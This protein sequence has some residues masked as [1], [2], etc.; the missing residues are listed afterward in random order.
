MS[1]YLLDTNVISELT[2]TPPNSDVIA[3]LLRE[4][5][6]WVPA[7][8]LHELHFGLQLLPQGRRR[9]GLESTIAAFIAAY[10]ERVLPLDR[11]AAEYAADLRA[12][13]HR[14]GRL[15]DIA[16]AFIAGTAMANDLLLATR[17]AADFDYLP[18]TLTNPWLG[19]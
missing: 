16:D 13:A 7:V 14:S 15:L 5:D 9:D 2:K 19:A 17:N 3:F 10:E 1:G 11:D 6:L 18:V 4:D 8:A 12:Y